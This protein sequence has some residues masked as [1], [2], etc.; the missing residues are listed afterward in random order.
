[1]ALK[2]VVSDEIE[3]DVKFTLNDG[4]KLREFGFR[5]RGARVKQD[6][7]TAAM[8]DSG[9]PVH[10]FLRQ[11]SSVRMLSWIGDAP[12][13]DADTGAAAAPGPE[14]LDTL[15]STVSNMGNVV[16]GAYFE[17]NGAKGKSGN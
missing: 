14:A 3:F 2:L 17:A 1:M 4:G 16:F 13:Q 5:A 11:R 6:E 9:V 10:E 8:R 7:L 12:L 15:M